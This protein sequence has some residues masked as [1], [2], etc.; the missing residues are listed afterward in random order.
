MATDTPTTVANIR[1]ILQDK[2][3]EDY[4]TAAITDTTSSTVTVNDIT[5]W[6]KGQVWE[7][8]DGD[9]GAEQILIRS[10]DASTSTPTFKRAHR[11]SAATTHL[12]DTV[13]LK[14]PRF[15]YDLVV[16][17]INSVIDSGL[18]DE[19]VFN[20]VEHQIT[21]SASTDYYN[22]PTTAC[23]EFLWVYQNINVGDPP[24]DVRDFDR[25]GRNVDTN[26]WSNGK[27]FG[28]RENYGVAGTDI[29]Y[30]NCKHRYTITTLDELRD[31][32]LHIVEWSACAFLLEWTEPKRLAG[33]TNQGDQTVRPGQGLADA[34]YYR[35][36]A[37]NAIANERAA[38]K[39]LNPP[40]RIFRKQV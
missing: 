24:T 26:L 36:L 40:Y 17:A 29:Y 31:G 13:M 22:A 38:L 32:P 16:Q 7:F 37:K 33:P 15:S 35:Q 19:G 11:D 39:G 12:I 14:D 2:P 27:V 20:I 4:I 5:K 8:D 30:V 34:S 18:Y 6:A 3:D 9:L 28:I 1:R 23:E 25:L 10:V 21:S